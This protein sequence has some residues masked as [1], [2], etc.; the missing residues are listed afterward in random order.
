MLRLMTYA[1]VIWSVPSASNALV[2]LAKAVDNWIKCKIWN[3]LT[4]SSMSVCSTEPVVLFLVLDLLRYT[5]QALE[6]QFFSRK[7]GVGFVV[8][9]N[10]KNKRCVLVVYSCWHMQKQLQSIPKEKV[11][12]KIGRSQSDRY[13]AK[14]NTNMVMTFTGNL[15]LFWHSSVIEANHIFNIV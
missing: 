4:L 8:V 2:L 10:I 14:I 6:K 3:V 15:N 9:M 7:V 1:V 12:V 13:L 5:L 11:A